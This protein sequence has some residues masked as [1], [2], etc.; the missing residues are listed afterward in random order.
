VSEASL[1][2]RTGGS[3]EANMFFATLDEATREV[4]ARIG[5][6]RGRVGRRGA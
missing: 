1:R 6:L 3:G 2:L 4:K 5:R